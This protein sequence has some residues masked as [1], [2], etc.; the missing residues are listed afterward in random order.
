[1]TYEVIDRLVRPANPVPDP[2]LLE[3]VDASTL[4]YERREVMPTKESI[5]VDLVEE[6]SR[7]GWLIGAAAA[8][9]VVIAAVVLSQTTDGS[10]VASQTPA[11]IAA[12]Y[13]EAYA[14]FDIA[15]VE[16]MLAEEAV[17]L[18]WE[19]YEPRDWK[20]DLRYLEAAGFEL[21]PGECRELPAAAGGVRVSCEYEAHGLGSDQIGEGPFG[22]NTFR[23]VIV[24]GLVVSSDM[25]FDFREFFGAM[26]SPFQT[27]IEEHHP[28][29]FSTLYV[30]PDLSRQTDEAIALWEQRVAD[31]V[32]Y[33]NSPTATTAAG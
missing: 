13:V 8:L 28:D 15:G 5:E 33:V 14:A 17:V 24:D 26:W 11:D 4:Q 3:P 2:R 9:V 10:G 25:G 23:L 32:E 31:Y 21:I 22:G 12:A 19:S 18:P 27:W 7:P 20:A 30:S 29:D 6:S 16:S 1:M